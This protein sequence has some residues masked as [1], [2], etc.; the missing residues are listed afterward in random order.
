MKSITEELRREKARIAKL[1]E[2]KAEKLLAFKQE[3]LN[4]LKSWIERRG[5][6]TADL[7]FKISSIFLDEDYAFRVAEFLVRPKGFEPSA[8][9]HQARCRLVFPL[10]SNLELN[11][12]TLDSLLEAL[13]DPERWAE[14]A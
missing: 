10:E 12:K 1:R 7:D 8:G 14:T 6:Q 4:T 11:E 13:L 9:F 2:E 3:A 5:W